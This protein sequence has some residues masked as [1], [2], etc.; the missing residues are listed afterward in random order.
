MNVLKEYIDEKNLF[1]HASFYSWCRKKFNI[2]LTNKQEPIGGK[3]SFDNENRK[4]FPSTFK[5]D[6]DIKQS[7][8]VFVHK[9]RGY[10]PEGDVGHHARNIQYAVFKL[11]N[12]PVTVINF[13]G[14]WNGKGKM[15]SEDRL[16]Q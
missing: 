2:L 11:H 15:D 16:E 13:H 5:N 8:D 7:G 3:W 1:I 4:A 12:R 14:L 9:E 10:M 6:I